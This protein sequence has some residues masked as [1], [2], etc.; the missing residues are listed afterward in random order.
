MTCKEVPL[1]QRA[2]RSAVFIII[3]FVD[4]KLLRSKNPTFISDILR[5]FDA[6]ALKIHSE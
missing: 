4:T 2:T 3:N 6:Y 1:R 5:V